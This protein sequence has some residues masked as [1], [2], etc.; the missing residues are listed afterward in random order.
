MKRGARTLGL[1][2]AVVLTGMTL[3]GCLGPLDGNGGGNAEEGGGAGGQGQDGRPATSAVAPTGDPKKP[4]VKATFDSPIGP[5]AKVDIAILD[6]RVTGKLAQ[7][8]LAITPHVVGGDDKPNVYELN[9]GQGPDVSLIDTVN[10]KRYMVVKDSSGRP[11]EPD[12]ITTQ[13]ANEQSNQ[14]TYFFAA[15]PPSVRNVDVVFGRWAPFRNVP[16]S[17]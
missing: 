2:V 13:L 7:L 9:G 8:T 15:P 4:I 1:A 6:L 12:Y 16:V 17:R 5:G 11:L 3:S 14:Q 10:L